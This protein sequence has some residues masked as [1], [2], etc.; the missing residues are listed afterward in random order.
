MSDR[1]AA[2]RALDEPRCAEPPAP[3]NQAQVVHW[4]DAEK[5]LIAL[6]NWFVENE[7]F[8]ADSTAWNFA[9]A[10]ISRIADHRDEISRLR[11]YALTADEARGI[12]KEIPG[13]FKHAS[14]IAVDKLI[15]M[16]NPALRSL[17][18]TETK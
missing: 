6:H 8:G 7:G 18:L 17:S 3:P 16:A 13:N 10:A 12:L 4:Q 9:M 11:E 1:W 2:F 5:A 15:E 14:D